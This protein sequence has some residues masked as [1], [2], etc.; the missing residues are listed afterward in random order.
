MPDL[1]ASPFS[2]IFSSAPAA[3]L[4]SASAPLP[5]NVTANNLIGQSI[6]GSALLELSRSVGLPA[7]QIISDS[8][9]PLT[10]SGIAAAALSADALAAEKTSTVL[11]NAAAKDITV[12][13]VNN[14]GLDSLLAQPS[15]KLNILEANSYVVDANS[16]SLLFSPYNWLPVDNGVQTSDAGAYLK[17]KFNGDQAILNVDTSSQTS[18]PLLDVYVDGKQTANQLWLKNVVDGQVE[19]FGGNNGDHDVVVYFRRRELYDGSNP[20]VLAIKQKDW[21]T[22][23]EHWRV[24]GV[25][26]SGGQGFLKNT[27][28]HS[29]TAVF[30]GD[31]ITEGYRQ[32]LDP[33]APPDRPATL[34]T[35]TTQNSI[36]YKTYAAQL[37]QLLNV[38]YGQISWSGA[39]WIQPSIAT[40]QPSITDSWLRYNGVSN[41]QRSFTTQPDYAFINMGTNDAA[42]DI[43]GTV[44]TWLDKARQ[45]LPG[46][47][48]FVIYPFN[49]SK[50]AQLEQGINNYKAN[51]PTDNKVHILNLGA[52][53]TLGLG[54]TYL[55]NLSPDQLHPTIE[56]HQQ[57]AGLLYEQIKPLVGLPGTIIESININSGTGVNNTRYN[58]NWDN[59]TN[60]KSG[61]T[62]YFTDEVDATYEVT[63]WG[64]HVQL[65][66]R[67]GKEEG[68]AA[69]S[70]DGGAESLTDLYSN[71]ANNNTLLYNADHLG[72]GFHTIK[73]RVTGQS[74]SRASGSRVDI[75]NLKI[76]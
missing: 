53:G 72:I 70:I 59:I 5:L 30:F 71:K 74:N 46:A 12:T 11:N 63:F 3:L 34:T 42:F 8:I 27:F 33:I 41:V 36:A 10:D 18:F 25:E 39:G 64:D 38:D 49:Q 54:G 65:F 68:I 4:N 57:L 56:R 29:K 47:E 62:R 67:K 22:D 43:T 9:I 37:G 45:T 75:G 13:G 48:I 2:D 28:A 35:P 69:I 24:T 7:L 32:Y 15:N 61:Y 14:T 19:L 66:G 6:A 73:V 52:E 58:G 16:D 31:S 1:I 40:G 50:T 44:S 21:L 23:A 76:W 60:K 55:P 51:H 20:D 26:V 17:F